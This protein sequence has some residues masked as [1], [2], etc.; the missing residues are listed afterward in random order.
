MR[1]CC[2]LLNTDE[3]AGTVSAAVGPH[4]TDGQSF[5]TVFGPPA[6]TEVVGGQVRLNVAAR[7]GVVL[8]ARPQAAFDPERKIGLE[9]SLT[10]PQFA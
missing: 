7:S 9:A 10:R 1:R 8:L 5:V 2:C 3:A 4:V 6:A